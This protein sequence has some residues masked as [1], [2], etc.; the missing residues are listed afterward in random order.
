MVKRRLG[1]KGF[2]IVAPEAAKRT[3]QKKH[4]GANAWPV[5]KAEALYIGN[6]AFHNPLASILIYTA[7]HQMFLFW[8]LIIHRS[9]YNQAPKKVIL[10]EKQYSAGCSSAFERALNAMPMRQMR[11][12]QM[13]ISM[14]NVSL[15]RLD[16]NCFYYIDLNMNFPFSAW[17]RCISMESQTAE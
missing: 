13:R 17:L 1:I 8:S 12:F 7:F 11:N 4:C 14:I 16:V 2:R 6:I 15:K 3:A 10:Y 5:M 9:L